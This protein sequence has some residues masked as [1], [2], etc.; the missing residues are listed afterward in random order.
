MTVCSADYVFHYTSD[1][2]KVF[3]VCKADESREPFVAPR[4]AVC[5]GVFPDAHGKA[6]IE[7]VD[8]NGVDLAGADESTID[9]PL[10]QFFAQTL[11]SV[12]AGTYTCRFLL[13]GAV[14]ADKQFQIS[15]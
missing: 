2:G 11:G 7:I 14:V 10:E 1:A 4:G 15:S 12:P 13:N 8:Q 6:S 5:D 9:R 3:P